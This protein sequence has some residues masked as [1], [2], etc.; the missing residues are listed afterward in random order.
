MLTA[1]QQYLINVYVKLNSAGRKDQFER[2]RYADPRQSAYSQVIDV[3][4]WNEA[5]PLLGQFPSPTEL[6]ELQK[7]G[8]ITI[9]S[10]GAVTATK[11]ARS[12]T[13]GS[14]GHI[15]P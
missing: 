9:K 5:G 14:Y 15:A 7:L 6:D 11:L 12:S 4:S 8:Y 3:S 2:G 10:N 13:T 1:R